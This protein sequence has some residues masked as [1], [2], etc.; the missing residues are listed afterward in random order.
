MEWA[1]SQDAPLSKTHCLL[2]GLPTELRDL[3][4]EYALT[5]DKTVVTFRLD[6]YQRESYNQ[7]TQPALTRVSRRVRR[8][9]LPIFYGR[10]S[11][12]LHTEGNKCR[13]ACSWLAC[14]VQHLPK[15]R[16]VSFWIR[17]LAPRGNRAQSQGALAVSLRRPTT[18]GQWEVDQEWRWV[19]V[20]RKPGTIE[21]DA[22][23]L[24]RKLEILVAEESKDASDTAF[25]SV[26]LAELSIYYNKQKILYF[27]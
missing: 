21:E 16:H 6:A 18:T 7:A 23:I 17:Y 13:D 10:N 1:P 25:F 27:L 3:I 24:L 14:N 8:E 26:I 15:L 9:T 22:Q 20:V 5:S 2:L 11:Y 4:Y 19:T 12:V